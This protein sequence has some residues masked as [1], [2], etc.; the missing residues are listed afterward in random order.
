MPVQSTALHFFKGVPGFRVSLSL[1]LSPPGLSV[2]KKLWFGN[3]EATRHLR[4]W[5]AR[6]L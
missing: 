6:S 1:S 5:A 4:H 2:L 3:P